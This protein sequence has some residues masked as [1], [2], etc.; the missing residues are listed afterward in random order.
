MITAH[1]TEIVYIINDNTAY[2][3]VIVI[4]LVL[5]EASETI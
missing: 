3:S 2:F 1:T 4:N 5:G